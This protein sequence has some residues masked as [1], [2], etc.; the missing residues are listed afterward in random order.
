MGAGYLAYV[1]CFIPLSLLAFLPIT[2]KHFY[3]GWM[4]IFSIIFFASM[5]SS[6]SY[7]LV[8]LYF[9]TAA[10]F[11]LYKN[12]KKITFIF[13]ILGSL[14]YTSG[15]SY[16]FQENT[17]VVEKFQT[18]S[19]SIVITNSID[20]ASLLPLFFWK[21]NS[22]A[23][24]LIDAFSDFSLSDWL[25][26]RGVFA[27]YISFTERSI[28]EIG[29]AQDTFR[30]GILYV[31]FTMSFLWFAQKKLNSIFIFEHNILYKVLSTLIIIKILDAFIF[32]VPQYSL[33]NLFVFWGLMLITI[34]K[35]I[36]RRKL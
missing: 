15:S 31:L 34:K 5:Q 26:G 3:I 1:N 7:I 10:F 30:F 25:F 28:I 32:G 33:Y 14:L 23:G 35:N 11:V 17:K 4:S 21:G 36:R 6:R 12:S 27:T 29:W 2:T 16:Y 9:T 22:R 13:I 20:S 8:G 24:I 18:D 19:P